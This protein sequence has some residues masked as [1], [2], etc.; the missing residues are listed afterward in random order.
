M[1][2]Q[3][4]VKIPSYPFDIQHSDQLITL[5]SCFSDEMGTQFSYY[6]FDCLSNFGGTLFHPLAIAK[7]LKEVQLNEKD[8]SYEILQREDVYFSWL[9]GGTVFEYSKEALISKMNDMYEHLTSYLFTAKVLF[10][11]FG[12]AK[13]YRLLATGKVVANCHKLPASNFEQSLT[14]LDELKYEWVSILSQLK[15]HYP[16][17]KVVFTVSPVRYVK[18]GLIENNR[19]KSRLFELIG[20]LEQT[21]LAIYFPAYEIVID[22]LRDYRFFKSDGFHPNELAVN[23]VWQKLEKSLMN[24]A[25]IVLNDKIGN[26]RKQFLHT[27]LYSESEVTKSFE[28]KRNALLEKLMHDYPIITW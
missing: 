3:N 12:S 25:T 17:L 6:G 18:D 4:E 20:E 9:M 21:G 11:T 24:D 8:R 13:G 5:G 2:F 1:Q 15:K 19:S 23:Y 27:S 16:Q 14:S 22:E 28:N 10:V 7:L 26:L